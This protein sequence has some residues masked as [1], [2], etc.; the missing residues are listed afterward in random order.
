MFVDS[1]LSNNRVL[2]DATCGREFLNSHGDF[3][4]KPIR[5]SLS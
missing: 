5:V 3:K 1:L 2:L 4:K